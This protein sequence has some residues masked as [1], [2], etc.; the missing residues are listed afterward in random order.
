MSDG[1]VMSS[2]DKYPVYGIAFNPTGST[3][4]ASCRDGVRLISTEDG[5]LV[6]TFE[7]NQLFSVTFSPNGEVLAAGGRG[8]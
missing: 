6:R 1:S 3:L 8:G 2:T 4:A 5:Q 7:G